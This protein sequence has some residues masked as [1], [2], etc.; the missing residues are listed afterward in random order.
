MKSDW[1][2]PGNQE[3]VSLSLEIKEL[4]QDTRVPGL[5][6]PVLCAPGAEQHV[7]DPCASCAVCLQ[8][9]FEEEPGG[10]YRSVTLSCCSWTQS[11]GRSNWGSERRIVRESWR[12]FLGELCK[13]EGAGWQVA[14]WDTVCMAYSSLTSGFVLL[15]PRS[16]LNTL[17][18]KAGTE[19]RPGLKA[20]LM[21]QRSRSVCCA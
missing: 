1:V 19:R 20:R 5:R 15:A 8:M 2:C 14:V 16:N 9:G 17:I 4:V 7:L 21:G 18:S 3:S 12:C 11:G 13:Q 10:V 6:S